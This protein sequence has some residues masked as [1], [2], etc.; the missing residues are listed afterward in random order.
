MQTYNALKFTFILILFCW[1]KDI[2]SDKVMD[3]RVV[4]ETIYTYK[5]KFSVNTSS[6]P[7]FL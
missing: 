4:M 7:N 2:F 5:Y 6:I 1:N 3:L